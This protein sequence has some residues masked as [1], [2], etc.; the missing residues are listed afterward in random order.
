VEHKSAFKKHQVNKIHLNVT[1]SVKA[2]TF[3]KSETWVALVAPRSTSKREAASLINYPQCWVTP[4][5]INETR[6]AHKN[7]FCSADPEKYWVSQIKA[8][9]DL[10]TPPLNPVSVGTATD[11][12]V[13]RTPILHIVKPFLRQRRDGIFASKKRLLELLGGHYVR[14]DCFISEAKCSCVYGG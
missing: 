7:I 3:F 14:T 10:S 5:K 12:K 8:E 2:N 13:L 6:T 4:N 1:A 11:A 9:R